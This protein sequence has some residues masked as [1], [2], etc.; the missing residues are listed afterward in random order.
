LKHSKYVT[1]VADKV[2]EELQVAEGDFLAL[3][4]RFGEDSCGWYFSPDPQ[5]DFCWGTVQIH[6]ANVTDVIYVITELA[7]EINVKV[8]YMAVAAHYVDPDIL[9]V[10]ERDF[11]KNN[12]RLYRSRTVSVLDQIDDNYYLSLIEQ[13][14][15]IRSKVFCSSDSSTWSEYIISWIKESGHTNP[16]FTSIG[17]QL[18]KTF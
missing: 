4:W 16:T 15:M 2:L 5:Y 10:L 14:I 11:T 17:D 13:E 1:N 3:H 8:I 12:I 6:F 18:K 7:K 9:A